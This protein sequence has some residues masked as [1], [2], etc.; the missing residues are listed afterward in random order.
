MSL[1]HAVWGLS[2]EGFKAG[3]IYKHLHSIPV[4]LMLPCGWASAGEVVSHLLNDL[5]LQL[6]LPHP[7]GPLRWH[8]K[9]PKA[10]DNEQ[11]ESFGAFYDLAVRS[12]SISTTV[13]S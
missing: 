6:A 3:I 8:L 2:W 12:P 10:S 1:L 9:D 5:F 11:D 13:F 4:Q 7:C